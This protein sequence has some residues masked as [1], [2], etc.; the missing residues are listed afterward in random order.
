MLAVLAIPV[1]LAAGCATPAPTRS[2]PVSIP[3]AFSET[4]DRALPPKWWEDFNNPTLNRLVE[5]AL[6]GNLTLQIAWDRL[7]QAEALARKAGADLQ[8]DLSLEA[9]MG[10][11]RARQ[12]TAAGRRTTTQDSFAL[13]L[14]ASYEVDLWGRIRS[15]RDAAVYDVYA[16]A[17]DLRA[18]AITLSAAVAST[19]V[20]LVEQRSQL[21]VIDS[22]IEIN[23]QVLEVVTLRF[24]R[25]QV[26]ASDVLRQRQLAESSRGVRIQAQARL[27]VLEHELAVLLGRAPGDLPD[28]GGGTLPETLPETPPLPATGL[29]AELIR[30]RPDIQA[31]WYSLQAADQRMAA[32]VADRFPRLS[33][34]A[35]AETSAAEFEDLFQNW[36]LAL[37]ANL[38][39]P[40]LD[41]GSRK[42]EVERAEAV[43][44][45]RLHLYGRA[46]LEALREV[47]NA[48]AEERLQRDYINSLAAQV[49]LSSQVLER[50][51]DNYMS[52]MTDYL[53]V[54]ESLSS[55]QSLERSYLAAQR[56]LVE[57]RIDLCRALAGGWEMGTDSVAAVH[58]HD[59][60][61][62]GWP[63]SQE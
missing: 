35:R 11:A 33:L 19:W 61:S 3:A 55:N 46:I 32:A 42:A 49:E 47:E 51:R 9:G 36:L 12:E 1:V 63:E 48:L 45:E 18:A 5:E 50:T 41:G 15:T 26:R 28:P 53:R 29:P 57:R 52:G 54:L 23:E 14:V 44:R 25:G 58:A 38:A 34:T 40:V 21:A 62:P 27:E 7:A 8:P 60:S 31:A 39:A 59:P 56:D 37:A 24:Q 30:E 22:Q 43:S 2:S 16:S 4:G 10:H 13:R 17:A 6:A 20:R